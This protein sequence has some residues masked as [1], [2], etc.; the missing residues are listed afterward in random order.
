[1]SVQKQPPI[2]LEGRERLRSD[3]DRLHEQREQISARLREEMQHRDEDFNQY[4]STQELAQLLGRITH[5]E[6]LLDAATESPPV[7]RGND[8]IVAVGSTVTITD[9]NGREQRYTIVTPAET[10]PSRG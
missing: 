7:P 4:V 8:G 3:L 1:M 9:E 10:D 6:S 2:T 5:I